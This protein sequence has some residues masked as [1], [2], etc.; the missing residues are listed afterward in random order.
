[1]LTCTAY[2]FVVAPAFQALC[3]DLVKLLPR[4]S[5]FLCARAVREKELNKRGAG[6]PR[7]GTARLSS[8]SYSSIYC[9]CQCLTSD[10]LLI[11]MCCC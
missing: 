7:L 11:I 10:F 9:S 5:F 2:H 3:T 8:Y 1:M 6:Y 4:P